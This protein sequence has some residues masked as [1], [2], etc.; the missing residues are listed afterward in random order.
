MP[1]KEKPYKL[2][3]IRQT[4]L[5][6][7]QQR[8]GN[9]GVT[10][11]ETR[12]G[13]IIRHCRNRHIE[14]NMPGDFDLTTEWYIDQII[15][16]G[17]DGFK[18]VRDCPMAGVRFHLGWKIFFKNGRLALDCT[19][20]INPYGPSVDRIDSS[21]GYTQDNCRVIMAHLNITRK[22]MTDKQ[23]LKRYPKIIKN[24]QS[25]YERFE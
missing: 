12:A 10:G 13:R 23:F 9:Y 8:R 3:T 6:K 20:K 25:D 17:D 15:Y 21:K 19:G 5:I 14:N 22:D 1:R 18:H 16:I 2:K 7:N 4:K 11:L 24:I